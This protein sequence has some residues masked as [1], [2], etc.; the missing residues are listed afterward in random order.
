LST[1]SVARFSEGSISRSFGVV[2]I[3]TNTTWAL[4]SWFSIDSTLGAALLAAGI[5]LLTLAVSIWT[6]ISTSKSSGRAYWHDKY[7][8]ALV[9]ALSPQLVT[10]E[11]GLM[12]LSALQVDSEWK[13][14]SV[15]SAL[16]R[17]VSARIES[18]LEGGAHDI[19]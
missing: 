6:L 11:V 2:T 4:W 14:T 18:S 10:A 13:G 17:S 16:I 15:E 8:S 5:A 3:A 19:H 7:E 1:A 12:E 9:R